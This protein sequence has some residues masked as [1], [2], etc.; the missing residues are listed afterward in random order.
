M[1]TFSNT[2]TGATSYNWDIAGF[3]TTDVNPVYSFPSNGQYTVVLTANNQ[4]CSST[5]TQTITISGVGIETA[6]MSD[7]LMVFPNP[8]SG[9]ITIQL[10]EQVSNAK[11]FISDMMGRVVFQKEIKEIKEPLDL[12]SLSPG[13]YELQINNENKTIH[14]RIVIQK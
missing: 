9:M 3:N 12:T 2:S 5:Y 1:V 8:T 7:N 4:G 10:S 11:L 14:Q 13:I 6:E